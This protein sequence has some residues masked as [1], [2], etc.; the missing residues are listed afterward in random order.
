V[1]QVGQ[2]K[3]RWKK[4][5]VHTNKVPR[6]LRICP[7]RADIFR[8][9]WDPIDKGDIKSFLSVNVPSTC[10]ILLDE[11]RIER[12]KNGFQILFHSTQHKEDAFNILR[13]GF[14]PSRIKPNCMHGQAFYFSPW[15]ISTRGYGKFT[16]VC[17]VYRP[18][19]HR[20]SIATCSDK[21]RCIPIGFI[22]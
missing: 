12:L 7:W 9:R 15:I 10:K 5:W 20:F 2:K 4:L 8:I 3:S 16:L 19:Y 17:A 13:N 1:E 22:Y 21:S 6:M 14:D 11:K 18:E